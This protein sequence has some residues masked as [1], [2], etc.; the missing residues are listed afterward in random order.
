MPVFYSYKA[1]LNM[2]L[3]SRSHEVPLSKT[4]DLKLL[5]AEVL[6]AQKRD[7]TQLNIFFKLGGLNS[8]SE[9]KQIS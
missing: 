6:P 4:E 3:K 2:L 1:F 8:N 5:K 7:I 9:Q